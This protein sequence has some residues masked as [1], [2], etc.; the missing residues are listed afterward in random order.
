MQCVISEITK[1]SPINREF[2]NRK[3]L[4]EVLTG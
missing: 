1:I 3:V 2:G 4:C